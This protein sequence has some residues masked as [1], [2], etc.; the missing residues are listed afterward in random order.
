VTSRLLSGA[1]AAGADASR[2]TLIEGADHG[3]PSAAIIGGPYHPGDYAGYLSHVENI[4]DHLGGASIGAANAMKAV[5]FQG[6]IEYLGFD[7]AGNPLTAPAGPQDQITVPAALTTFAALASATNVTEADLRA[8]NP[9]AA[10]PLSGRLRAPGCREHR[11]VTASDGV[12]TRAE[13]QRVIATQ[14]C[15]TEAALTAANPG[16]NFTR[17]V[18]GQIIIIPKH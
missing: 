1:V 10:E 8:A 15:V 17:L 12:Q 14:H 9:G 3:A 6:H 13:T 7:H 5:F 18:D 16:V 2:R 11:V 4:Q